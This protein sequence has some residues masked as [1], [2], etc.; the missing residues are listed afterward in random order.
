MNKK[1]FVGLVF[2]LLTA[3][4]SASNDQNLNDFSKSNDVVPLIS[5]TLTKVYPHDTSSFTEGLFAHNKKLYESTG[6]PSE[7]PQTKSVFGV[8]DS[9]TGKIKIK[10][11]LDKTKY[12]GEGA[13]ILKD[14]IYQLT[15]QTKVGFIYNAQTF[16]KNGEFT[17][18]SKE[19]WGL[20]TDG[21]YLIMSDGTNQITYLD[22][23]TFKVIKKINVTDENGA[24]NNLNELEYINGLIYANVYTTNIIVKISPQDGNVKGKL[25]LSQLVKQAR[26]KYPGSLEMNG[27]AYDS[28]T[29]RVFITGK[30]WPDIYEIN[31]AH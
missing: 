2:L 28:S 26:L 29:D 23:N 14:K 1:V 6:S 24:V 7:I 22:P 18:P 21:I 11:E 17:F 13:I 15:Y 19:G 8:V 16:K 20:T 25:E 5:Y 30:M 4:N 3:C 12:F 31:F 27:I 9:G 10:I